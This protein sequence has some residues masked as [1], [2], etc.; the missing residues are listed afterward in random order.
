VVIHGMPS[1][2]A[3][4]DQTNLIT[5]VREVAGSLFVTGLKEDYYASF[6][7]GWGDFVADLD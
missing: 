6:W 5:G 2:L 1:T 3:R 4:Q 7:D